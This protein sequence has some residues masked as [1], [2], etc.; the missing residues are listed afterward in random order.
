MLLNLSIHQTLN[1]QIVGNCGW[2]LIDCH[3]ERAANTAPV[4]TFAQM[5][6]GATVG[7]T[8]G[9]GE[10][11]YHVVEVYLGLLFLVNCK[12]RSDTSFPTI[13]PAM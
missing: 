6:L 8:V 7:K 4:E 1:V 12:M 2:H 3:H 10:H 13:Q 5:P 9:P 11:A